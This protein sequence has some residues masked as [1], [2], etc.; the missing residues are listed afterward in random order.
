MAKFEFNVL[1]HGLGG[2]GGKHPVVTPEVV[3]R[4]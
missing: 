4:P 2:G 1:A 3:K